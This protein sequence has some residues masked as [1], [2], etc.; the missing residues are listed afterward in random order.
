M[1]K[2]ENYNQLL[3]MLKYG[4]KNAV[5]VKHLAGNFEITNLLEFKRK[6]RTLAHKARYNGHWIIRDSRGYYLALHRAEWESYKNQRLLAISNEL[7][8]IA[9]CDNI[10]FSD[11][12]K[13]VYGVT[14]TDKN[15]ELF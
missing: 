2:L 14:P 6:V 3:N 9:N 8:A 4:K 12:I 5:S 15:Y 13:T 11:L 1:G 10:S 7:K